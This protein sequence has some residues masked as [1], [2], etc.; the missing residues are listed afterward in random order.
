MHLGPG[1]E[2]NDYENGDSI[3]SNDSSEKCGV[4]E[5]INDMELPT[6]GHCIHFI[7][8]NARSLCPKITS[9]IDHIHELDL[10]FAAITETWFKGGAQLRQELDDIEQ[11]SGVKILQR[12]RDGRRKSRGGG[13]ALA[14]RTA[15]ATFKERKFKNPSGLEIL[16]AAG[17]V[18][19]IRRKVV[20]FVVYVP[21]DSKAATVDAVRDL[22]GLELAAA[23]VAF[24][25]PILV[26]CGDMNGRRIEGA[27]DIDD[28]FTLVETGNTRGDKALD[29]VFTNA[30]Q[31]VVLAGTRP[32]LETESGISSDHR[33]VEVALSLPKTKSLTYTKKTTRRRTASADARFAEELSLRPPVDDEGDVDVIVGRFTEGLMGLTDKHFPL[34]TTS[35]RSNEHPWITNGIRRR[36]KR[37]KRLFRRTGRSAA[38]RRAE[39]SMLREIA[40]KKQ[41]FVEKL[42]DLPG[43]NYY[44]AVKQL[45][46]CDGS[47]SWSVLD[48]FPGQTELEIGTKILDY[49][50]GVGGD[51]P[52]SPRPP[53]A[54]VDDAGLGPFDAGRAEDLLRRH[55]KTRSVVEGDPMPHLIQKF[56]GVF[57]PAVA[58]IFNRVNATAS[59]PTA[60]KREYLT[61][62]PK[63]PRP[64]NLSE[65]RNISCTAYLIKVLEGVLLEK[66]RRELQP[67][68]DQFGG[69]K[70]CGPEHMMV[71]IWD[72]ILSAMDDGDQAACL[73][74]I[75]F[76]KAFNRMDHGHCLRQLKALGASD[77][78]LALVSSFLSNQSM[79]ITLNGVNCGEKEIVRGSPQGSVLGCLLYCITTQTLT[80]F[81]QHPPS[82][83]VYTSPQA[84]VVLDDAFDGVV[85]IP[86]IQDLE[87][88]AVRR[89]RF[90]PSSSG[91]DDSEG[92]VRFWEGSTPIPM[93]GTSGPDDAETRGEGETGKVK[94]VDDTTL[95]QSVKMDTAIR[96][97]STGLTLES[98]RP[99][100]LEW[101]LGDLAARAMDIG[102]NV[103]VKKTQLLCI[104]PR[105]GCNTTAAILAGGD[106]GWI[107]STDRMKL[108]GFTF[109]PSPSVEF[110]VDAIREEYRRKVWLLFHLHE[111]GIRGNNLFRL[112]CVYIRSRIEYLS[113]AYHSMLLVGQAEALERL[114]RYAVRVCFGFQGDVGSSWKRRASIPSAPGGNGGSIPSSPK[115]QGIR[116]SP[117]GSP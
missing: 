31:H 25:D 51:E 113:S 37:K 29:L 13:V 61:I 27:F 62:I 58:A 101:G 88:V 91:S 45:A 11:A 69:E 23:K 43:R 70:K 98:L 87:V 24:G 9:L 57:A 97:C 103:N 44:S 5:E 65:C 111:A 80:D 6:D 107:H 76:E 32:P 52:P 2:E 53:V 22:L 16:C 64:N 85:G 82:S 78:S 108:V 55:K 109:G 40:S 79:T 73:L 112:Y 100:A 110:H 96:H 4:N 102:M 46:G 77:S 12:N 89:P 83:P 93:V 95:F 18:G 49:F 56:P 71:E 47:R 33:F 50:S 1:S 63:S 36:A 15:S 60:W 66:L 48:M 39:E 21:P 30:A 34:Q 8:T 114:H 41:E 68:P 20:V 3:T 90:F 115:P 116:G 17:N 72:K 99:I 67:D 106:E 35:R 94:Y 42:I 54:P 19:T 105:N 59:W 38:W 104:S 86:R 28:Q 26:V 117:I 10:N 84:G 14:F 7:L 75:D 81:H 74:G 92:D